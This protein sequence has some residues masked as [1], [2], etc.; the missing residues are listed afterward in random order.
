MYELEDDKKQ[1]EIN[2]Q[3]ME[4]EIEE[5]KLKL[6]DINRFKEWDEND[7]LRWIFSINNGYLKKYE[8]LI[9]YTRGTDKGTDLLQIH[10]KELREFGI[11]I[12]A[13]QTPLYNKLEELR[14]INDNYQAN[15]VQN[16][17]DQHAPLAYAE[18]NVLITNQ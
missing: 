17:H 1:K 15:V 9:I 16:D 4:D 8:K 10:R 6:I 14:R 12:F 5:L 7:V 13:D 3:E 18:G 2:I 11:I